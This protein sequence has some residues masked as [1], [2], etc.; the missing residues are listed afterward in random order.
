MQLPHAHAGTAAL[1]SYGRYVEA[2]LLM[3]ARAVLAEEVKRITD[4]LKIAGRQREDAMEQWRT[5]A[6]KRDALNDRFDDV[7]KIARKQLASRGVRAEKEAP[8]TTVFPQGI[9]VYVKAT[10]PEQMTAMRTFLERLARLPEGDAVRAAAEP[11][12]QAC[13]AEWQAAADAVAETER[14]VVEARVAYAQARDAWERLLDRTY[15]QLRA[16]LGR[17]EAERFFPRT[18]RAGT[19]DD[20]AD[21]P[22]DA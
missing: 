6:A 9:D 15:G 21:A 10:L 4:S 17:E 22:V 11:I 19:D 13:V 7:V 18:R 3:M 8:Y 14:R 12:V 5:A 1:L 16:E 2:R 20:T